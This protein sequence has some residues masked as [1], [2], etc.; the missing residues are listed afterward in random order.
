M[1]VGRDDELRTITDLLA[2]SRS[3]QSQVLVLR[4]EAGV[5]KSTL[6]RA[7]A[8]QAERSGDMTV[9]SCAGVESEVQLAFSGLHQLLGGVLDQLDNLPTVQAKAVRGAL[10]LSEDP[11]SDLLVSA[12]VLTLLAAVAEERP[13]LILVDD[14]QWLD[15]A[16][17]GALL[18]AFRRLLAE[19][20]AVLV[21]LRDPDPHAV[22]TGDLPEL[23]LQ[24]LSPDAA[25]ALLGEL[26]WHG[27]SSLT[28]TLL[29]LTL[30]NPLALTE[31]IRNNDA[32]RLADGVALAG[33][34]PVS[35]RLH[36]AFCNGV[37]ELSRDAR[38]M[39]LVAA[40]DESGN[41]H[42]VLG[43]AR[44]LGVQ[45]AALD[46]LERGSLIVTD[47]HSL[48]FRHPLI[49]S[50]VYQDAES[51]TRAAVHQVLGD[52][53]TVAGQAERATWHHA[54]ACDGPDERL[55]T[56]LEQHAE[57]AG[58][59]G[60]SATV[61]AG[62]QL[63]ARLSTTGDGRNR[64]L[65]AAAFAATH[66]GQLRLA[67]TLIDQ[68]LAEH[69]D[70]ATTIRLARLRGLNELDSGDP[71]IAYAQLTY[72]AQNLPPGAS[73]EAASILLLAS[74]AAYHADRT[75][76]AA[77]AG[78]RIAELDGGLYGQLGSW[79][80]DAAEGRLP[81]SET[82]PR[83]VAALAEHAFGPY[84][85]RGIFWPAVIGWLGPHERQARDF[86]VEA[87]RKLRSAG[88][89]GALPPLLS[90]LVD[91]EYRLG[92]WSAGRAHAD[93]GLRFAHEAGQQT[94]LADLLA[95]RARLAAVWGDHTACR[96][97]S[98][99]ALAVAVRHGNRAATANATWAA[100]LLALTDGDAATAYERL[101]ELHSPGGPCEH[102]HVL[103]AAV[104]DLV[105]AAVR[106]GH[107]DMAAAVVETV[108]PW[109]EG[110]TLPWAHAHLHRCRAL[111]AGVDADEHYQ[112]A[113]STV[114]DRPFD[115][116]R[117]ALLYGEWLRRDRRPV[118]ARAQLKLAVQLLDALGAVTLADRARAELRAAGGSTE[119]VRAPA[120]ATLT[121]QELQVAQLAAT[122]LS[123]R[124][125]AHQL[126]LSPRT[127]G[128]HLYK[129]FPKLGIAHRGQLRGLDLDVT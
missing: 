100:G 78:R 76:D 35:A 2:A 89:T 121:P 57:A 1:I 69:P 47:D 75:D 68:V 123:N 28:E 41:R 62:L 110:S 109:A 111:L 95:L 48:R 39:L 97:D 63:A 54:L 103:R 86:G 115:R 55:A 51:S 73:A 8:E 38:S 4:G 56:A 127:V 114:G 37:S 77:A 21:A 87:S 27:P 45:P 101:F 10:G 90:M 120:A 93:E 30:G 98:D 33:M 31:L 36:T 6:L 53:L 19:P 125:I 49:R 32:D 80:G 17:S 3:G 83:E 14:G 29:D 107:H 79:L 124:E 116:A 84:D 24:G 11:A 52:E 112:L 106:V 96:R 92:L 128:Y 58:S 108:A 67:E 81:G 85:P 9:L 20:I 65:T 22:D 74:D 113:L 12:G 40:A 91:L 129:V 42:T 70:R 64:R 60:G 25:S 122:G 18:F 59:R 5:G 72:A 102:R 118:A 117:T 119:R 94:R 126:F 13:L 105:E 26:G 71:S 44:R 46:E 82:S 15:Y 34:V 23:R 43:A 99:H 7:A 50:A 61:A 88:M 16:S 66:A 104:P